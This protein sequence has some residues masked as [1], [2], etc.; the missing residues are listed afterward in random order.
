M[1]SSA[2]LIFALMNFGSIMVCD[3]ATT[4]ALV[5]FQVSIIFFKNPLVVNICSSNDVYS[6][7]LSTPTPSPLIEL[8]N[9]PLGEPML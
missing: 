1:G 3:D 9:K 5:E 8:L 6:D 7:G 2:L 4:K